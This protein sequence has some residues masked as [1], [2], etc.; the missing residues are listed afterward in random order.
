M[1]IKKSLLSLAAISLTSAAMTS[2]VQAREFGDIFT[3]C[4]IGAAVFPNHTKNEDTA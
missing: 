4:G 3:E 2:S 1:I